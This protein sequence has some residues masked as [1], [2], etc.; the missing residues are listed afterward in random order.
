MTTDTHAKVSRDLAEIIDLAIHL[1]SQAVHDANATIDGTSLPGGRA[2]VALAL[3]A[4]PETF[5]R[6]VELTEAQWFAYAE[7]AGAVRRVED[8]DTLVLLDPDHRP[9]PAA[10]EDD[11]T[12]PA[13]QVLRYWTE[14]C[15][16]HLGMVWD[17][18]PTL[19]TEA[20]F[21]RNPDVLA[22]F[23]AEH[24]DD[25]PHMAEDVNRA[26]RH[27]E[28]IL[29]AGRRPDRSRVV[30]NNPTCSGATVDETTGKEKRPQL[31][32]THAPAY[33]TS[34]TCTACGHH[35]PETSVCDTCHAETGPSPATRCQRLVG[36]KD[37]RHPCG[38]NLTSTTAHLDRC[39]NLW[40][41]TTTPPTPT[42]TSDEDH[43]GWKCTS[44]K[45]RYDAAA[46]ADAH[47]AMLRSQ[48][49]ERFVSV[50]DA[51]H[52][53]VK[54]GRPEVTVRSWLKPPRRHTADRCTVCKR[55]WPPLEH[56]VCPGAVKG[57]LEKCGGEL[58]PVHRGN[59][60]Q[61]I[62]AYCDIATHQTYVWWPDIWR[63]HLVSKDRAEQAARRRGAARGDDVGRIGA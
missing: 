18:I 5:E 40:C 49:A 35:L 6:R 27:L 3:A 29:H 2:M 54:Q 58:R 22:H 19:H 60:D 11:D 56:N 9:D 24:P 46:F 47:K 61:V 45:T 57:S 14:R 15:R 55:T 53:L 62:E 16:W 52:T 12:A 42:R 31:I 23:A 25:W 51:V 48:G 32:R 41:A 44:C 1:S 36:R 13:L 39:P 28:S 30:C 33:V 37:D 17:H 59:A 10:D 50:R 34:W 63:R 43:D 38:G 26:R 7:A 4:D 20:T 8:L 21:L